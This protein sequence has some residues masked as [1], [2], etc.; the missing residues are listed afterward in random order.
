MKYAVENKEIILDTSGTECPIPVLKARKL[1]QN[2][3]D[4]CIVKVIATDPL[5]EVDFKHYCEQSQYIYLDCKKEKEKFII[6]YK[7]KKKS[8]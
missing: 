7:F 4:G 2:L 3:K 5:A 8:S 1:S 6:R